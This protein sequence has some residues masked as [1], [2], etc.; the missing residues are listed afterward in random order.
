MVPSLS[1]ALA[2]S[3]MLAGALKVAPPA[4]LVR[5]TLGGTLGAL[6][7]ILTGVEVA[8]WSALF[9]LMAVAFA[10]RL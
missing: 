7:V 4:G 8:V 6:T 9:F 1:L 5:L 2:V 3:V 10:V